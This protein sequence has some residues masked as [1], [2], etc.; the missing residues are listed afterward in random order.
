MNDTV[1]PMEQYGTEIVMD[2]VE[3]GIERF[4]LT[5]QRR[6]FPEKGGRLADLRPHRPCAGGE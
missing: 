3:V 5:A 2:Q 4:A 1:A 6:V